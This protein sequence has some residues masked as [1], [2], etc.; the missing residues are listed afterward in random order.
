[1][2]Q[3]LWKTARWFLKTPNRELPH[4]SAIPLL[5]AY[6][7][8]FKYLYTSFIAALLTLAKSCKQPKCPLVD[9]WISTMWFTQTREYYSVLK[10]NMDLIWIERPPQ[11]AQSFPPTPWTGECKSPTLCG[12]HLLCRVTVRMQHVSEEHAAQRLAHNIVLNKPY[13][14]EN[15]EWDHLILSS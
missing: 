13:F 2:V 6:P 8:E 11:F 14:L 15:R 5:G 4:D 9:E 12:K 1:M 7:K 10:R 3:P